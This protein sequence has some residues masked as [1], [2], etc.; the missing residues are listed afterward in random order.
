MATPV[1]PMQGTGQTGAMELMSNQPLP[2]SVM[3]NQWSLLFLMLDLIIVR[4]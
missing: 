3:P 4:Q 1:G 2:I